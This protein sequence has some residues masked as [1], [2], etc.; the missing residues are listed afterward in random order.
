MSWQF[1]EVAHAGPEHL[2]PAYVAAFDIKAKTDW[3]E[4]IAT[5]LA[6]GIGPASTIVDFGAGTGTFAE[7]IAGRVARVVSVDISPA[8][9]ATMQARG[10]EAIRAGF[11]SYEH[12]G[13]PP[14]AIFSSNALHHLPDFW[15]AIAL[16]R[17]ARLL[18]PGGVLRLS[19][20]IYSFEA[21]GADQAIAAWLATASD[22]RSRGWTASEL[23]AV[24][25]HE[26]ATFTWLLE[27]MLQ[28]AGLEIRDRWIS[29]NQTFAAY[30]CV[31]PQSPRNFSANRAAPYSA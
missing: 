1:D 18:R 17:I 2:N 29:D 28:H 8:M 6:L 11:L 25:R 22:D 20:I 7:A 15:K 10:L 21:D 31:L 12:T 24:I 13:E 19:D 27:P 26:H 4:E 5:L 3:S 16:Q 30:S 23:A 14:D 9:V